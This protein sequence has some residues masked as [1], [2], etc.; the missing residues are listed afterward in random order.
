MSRWNRGL[1]R[2][3]VG[4]VRAGLR[5]SA[6]VTMVAGFAILGLV[7][8]PSG[9]VGDECI[10]EDEYRENFPGFSITEENIESRSFQCNTRICLVNHF[11]GRVSC[12]SGQP[13]PVQCA[14]DAG[15]EECESAVCKGDGEVCKVAGTLIQNCNPAQCGTDGADPNNCT[16][17]D[18]GNDA[19]AP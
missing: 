6:A 2:S 10:P 1:F 19:D 8:C 12:P 11:Q 9:G 15:V 13:Q 5:M 4:V 17:D 16:K 3:G 7:G 14:C 18:G